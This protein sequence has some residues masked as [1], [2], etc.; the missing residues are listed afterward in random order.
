MSI[1]ARIEDAQFLWAKGR[2]EGAFLSALVA[3][4]ATSRRI[5][6]YPAHKDGEAFERFLNQGVFGRLSA[7]FRG[8]VLP[9][10]RIFYKWV[11]CQLAHEGTLPCDLDFVPGTLT[12]PLSI[13]AGGAP[14]FK[15]RLSQSWFHEIVHTVKSAPVNADIFTQTSNA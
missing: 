8:E 9:V 6:P 2:H 7:V 12:G 10:Y 1:K 4:A 11:R 14:E 3:I 5:Y 13:R 15:L